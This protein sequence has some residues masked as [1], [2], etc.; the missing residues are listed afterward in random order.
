MRGA[1]L[2][3]LLLLWSSPVFG[4]PCISSAGM[5]EQLDR[6]HEALDGG[7]LSAV[8]SLF[9]VFTSKGG[10]TWTLLMVKPD[11]MSCIIATGYFWVDVSLPG[12]GSK[13]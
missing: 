13:S 4:A 5:R 6:Y 10:K 8:G 11:G 7:G 1:L 2:V 9:Q 12:T 3:L